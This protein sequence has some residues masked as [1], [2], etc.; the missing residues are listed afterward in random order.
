[1]APFMMRFQIRDLEEFSGVRA[2]TIRIWEKRYGLLKPARTET[3]IRTY[4]IE[5]LK[6]IL[7][8]AFLNQHG[9]KI[10]KIAA[11]PS[12]ERDRLVREVALSGDG[13]AEVVKS[14]KM[15]M[16]GFDE[17]LFESVGSK[18]REMHGFRALVEE[19]YV[20][21][22]EHIGTLWQ[23]N[24]ICPAHEHFVSN[25]IRQKLVAAVD[26][27]PFSG[28]PKERMHILYLPENELHELGLLY[29]NFILRSK[30]ER[31]IYLGQGVPLEDLRQVASIMNG[32]I[33]FISIITSIP[34]SPDLSTMLKDL[35][36]QLNED[37]F[38]FMLAS[39][40]FDRNLPAPGRMRLFTSM[41]DLM[42][43][44]DQG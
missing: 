44:V 16:L 24:S 5:D 28:V 19:V 17:V 21:L 13:R 4:D 7:N 9:L 37:R 20:P 36:T 1:M 6:A 25:I 10:S 12:A 3:N 11:L 23:T 41:A 8:V 26:A 15:A 31:T 43:A 27:L 33:T 2:H 18:F 35:G 38:D 42:K 14:L 30:G 32:P 39:N 40:Q 34:R 29:L 22:L